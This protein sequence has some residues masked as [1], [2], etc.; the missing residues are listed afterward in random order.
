METLCFANGNTLFHRQKQVVSKLETP[1]K[2]SRLS[3]GD[4]TRQSR[5]SVGD[6]TR[7]T[8]KHVMNNQKP[9]NHV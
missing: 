3:V 5:L 7:M 8:R 9:P 2:Q 4:D 6:D 1:M